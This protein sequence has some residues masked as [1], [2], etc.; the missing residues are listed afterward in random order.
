MLI[1]TSCLMAAPV[2][3]CDDRIASLF[4]QGV[5]SHMYRLLLQMAVAVHVLWWIRT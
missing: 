4:R 2:V 3:V 5:R 1:V